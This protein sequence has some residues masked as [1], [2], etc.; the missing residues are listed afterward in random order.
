M[1][2]IHLSRGLQDV[3]ERFKQRALAPRDSFSRSTGSSTCHDHERPRAPA[4]IVPDVKRCRFVAKGPVAPNAPSTAPDPLWK[5]GDQARHQFELYSED[6][7]VLCGENLMNFAS[8]LGW[9]ERGLPHFLLV[10]FIVYRQS[11]I[12][13][14]SV[15]VLQKD[16]WV[17]AFQ[18]VGLANPTTAAEKVWGELVADYRLRGRPCPLFLE[19]YRFVFVYL[20]IAHAESCPRAPPSPFSCVDPASQV[21]G[22]FCRTIPS[23]DAKRGLIATLGQLSPFVLSFCAFLDASGTKKV[24]LDQW[25][26][27][28][29][30]SRATNPETVLV[31][32]RSEDCWSTLLDSY[33]GWLRT[34]F[35]TPRT[36]SDGPLRPSEGYNREHGSVKL[37]RDREDHD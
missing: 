31:R 24:N 35:A 17:A 9:P 37:R 16:A 3:V 10:A 32:H 18:Q 27:F 13:G 36:L 5:V 21:Y 22:T 29:A 34:S 26:N 28:V 14:R 33:V 19:F 2:K 23:L 30:F 6:N 12:G 1:E 11:P 7:Q 15:V 20:L 25:V 4:D 8:E